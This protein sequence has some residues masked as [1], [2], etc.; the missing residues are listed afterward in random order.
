MGL[1]QSHPESPKYRAFFCN[2]WIHFFFTGIKWKLPLECDSWELSV[3]D[4]K[5]RARVK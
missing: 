2:V 5:K 3:L 4:K 1:L